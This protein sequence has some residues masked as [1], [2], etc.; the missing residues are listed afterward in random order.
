MKKLSTFSLI[1]SLI[2]AIIVTGCSA[3]YHLRRAIK[4]GYK[5]EEVGDTIRIT[6][7]DSFPVIRDN[8]IVYERYYTTK[9]TIVQYKTSYVPQTRWQ[10]R[11]EYRL[12]RDTI[13]QVQKVEVAKYKSQKEKPV[14]WVLILGF[15]IGMGT[16]YLFRY[17]N[18]NK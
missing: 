5:C 4:K 18:I 13:R 11:I 12:K 9:D 17:S 15:V 1:L 7:I 2:L 10:T 16:M 6:T 14:F 8:Q 3:N